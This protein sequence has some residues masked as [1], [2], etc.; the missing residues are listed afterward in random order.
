MRWGFIG[1][2]KT[3]RESL[4]R[5]ILQLWGEGLFGSL[6]RMVMMIV[7]VMMSK[8]RVAKHALPPG[9]RLGK[10]FFQSKEFFLPVP[11]L[12]LASHSGI[13]KQKTDNICEC[14]MPQTFTW[15][16]SYHR[17]S[18]VLFHSKWFLNAGQTLFSFNLNLKP[19]K[20]KNTMFSLQSSWWWW[21]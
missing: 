17:Q 1:H 7:M 10:F 9:R 3:Q 13:T 6:A 19:T 8:Q 11:P 15:F 2:F 20:S 21:L 16:R 14:R 18:L 5:C 4:K 12:H